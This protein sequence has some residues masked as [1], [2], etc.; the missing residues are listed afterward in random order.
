MRSRTNRAFRKRFA[1]LPRDIQ[2]QARIAYRQF[3]QDPFHPGLQFKQVDAANDYW[4]ARVGLHT[5]ALGR[6]RGEEVEWYWIGSHD[7][8]DRLI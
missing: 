5:R 2:S 6:R 1:Q 4:S 7:D 3:T 8:Y